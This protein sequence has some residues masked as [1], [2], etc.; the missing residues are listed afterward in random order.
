MK[1]ILEVPQVQYTGETIDVPVVTQVKLFRKLKSHRFNP[2]IER[3]V[4][5]S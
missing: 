4:S 1:K 3:L 5:L 2:L